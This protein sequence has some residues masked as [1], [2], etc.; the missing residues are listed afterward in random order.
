[1]FKRLFILL[2]LLVSIVSV[3]ESQVRKVRIS[4]IVVEGNVKSEPSTIRLNSGLM[5]G[6]EI[7]GEDIQQAL[8][9]LWSLKLFADVQ[10]LA[11]NQTREGIDLIIR[12]EEYPRLRKVEISGHEEID[13]DEIETEISVYRGMV[14]TPFKLFKIR[15]NIK[16]LYKNEGF[17]LAEI[18]VDTVKVEPGYVNITIDINEGEEVQIESINFHGNVASCW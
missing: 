15:K 2:L 11:A 18:K 9:N 7:S 3:S 8:K 14:V 6:K 13:L 10:I 5:V 12:V 17:L 1:M 4:S 16:N